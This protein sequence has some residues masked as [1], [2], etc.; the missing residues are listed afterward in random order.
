MKSFI[1]IGILTYNNPIS[2]IEK[3]LK[4]IYHQDYGTD[5]F[6][7]IIRNQGDEK[8]ID[9]II[10]V[11]NKLKLT[12]NINQG[13]NIG[14]GAGH[15]MIFKK[16]DPRS[17]A[18]LCLNPDGILHYQGLS[19]MVEFLE[20]HS[21]NCIVEAIQEPIM[22]PKTYNPKTGLTEWCSGACLLIPN[23][24]YSEIG[25]F[26]DDFFMYC[27]DVD[28]SW[29]VK[30]KG[31]QCYTCAEALFFH[32]AVDRS[33]RLGEMYKSATILAHKWRCDKFL[34]DMKQNWLK[35]SNIIPGDIDKFL[36]PIPQNNSDAVTNARPNFKNGLYF[37]KT[38][39]R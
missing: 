25:G 24:I 21:N 8:L 33:S 34:S 6:E 12:I 20:N 14:F 37:S 15:N 23:K 28:L 19:R 11:S 3:C 7:V 35:Y 26:D 32:Y 10:E 30:A 16:I 27:E 31:Y 13:E 39:W 5:N 29:R 1:S 36:V 17:R 2:E 38:M 4:S 18:Y 9:E 22:H